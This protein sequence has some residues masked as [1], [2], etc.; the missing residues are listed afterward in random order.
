[1]KSIGFIRYALLLVPA[2]AIAGVIFV[3][4]AP[5]LAESRDATLM[6]DRI[7][8]LERE[9]ETMRRIV[10][11][12]GATRPS[13]GARPAAGARPG[14]GP[15]LS[16]GG[17][18]IKLDLLE[19]EIRRLTG[20]VERLDFAV[21]QANERVK[22]LSSDIDY[23]LSAIEKSGGRMP[24]DGA[25]ANP[26]PGPSADTGSQTQPSTAPPT[27][28]S[29]LPPG[30]QKE[31]YD[32][33]KSLLRRANYD[34]AEK[35]LREFVEAYPN[36]PLTGNALY[37]LGETYYVRGNFSRA[38]VR[39]ADG[40]KR[41]P[42]HPKG[43]DNLLKLGMSLGKLKKTRAA[44][45]SLGQIGRQYPNAAANIKRTAAAER[46]RMSCR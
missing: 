13:T 7:L 26:Q 1:M 22:A 27:K 9:L 43:P 3:A 36:G 11:S 8:R 45:A 19:G 41:F 4:P 23:R 6:R 29:A 12:R 37:W 38:A 33:A 15:P 32:H 25:V 10:Q 31:Q 39:F 44:C 34:E 17:T 28:T 2:L 35:A 21:R 16:A 40:Y 14:A 5:A 24:A 20:R 42:N 18:Q 46:K 30:S